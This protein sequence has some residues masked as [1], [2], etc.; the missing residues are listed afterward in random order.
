M[1][2]K[3]YVASGWFN[4]FERTTKDRL[5]YDLVR[6]FPTSEI[7]DPE[8]LD[9]DTEELFNSTHKKEYAKIIYDNN[10]KAIQDSNIVVFPDNTQDGGTI[11]D[12]AFGVN[13]HKIVFS[14]N[15]YTGIFTRIDYSKLRVPELDESKVV[16]MKPSNLLKTSFLLGYYK[17][18]HINY[19]V[20]NGAHDNIMF[21]IGHNR[22]KFN[23]ITLDFES[24]NSEISE[25]V[26]ST[27]YWRDDLFTSSV[28]DKVIDDS[29]L[30]LSCLFDVRTK[31]VTSV[32]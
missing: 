16:I 10:I 4:P 25:Q 9:P 15:Y 29:D 11:S 18:K 2:Q 14:Y 31:V 20:Y 17:D 5:L 32:S 19:A 21:N 23:N 7:L 22:V 26:A 12:V 8:V 6:K 13:Q 28:L 27:E 30:D 1:T 3:I 24:I